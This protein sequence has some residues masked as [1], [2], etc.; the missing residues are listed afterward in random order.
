MMK[1]I[2]WILL[3]TYFPFRIAGQERRLQHR[4]Y[5]DMRKFHYGFTIGLHNQGI[6]LVNNGYIDPSTGKQWFAVNDRYDAGLSVG[7]LGEWRLNTYLAL[8]VIPSMHFGNKHITFREQAS[9]ETTTQNMKSTYISLPI[10]LKISAPRFNNYRPYIIAGLNPMYDLTTR[11]QDYLLAKPLNLFFEVGLGC[12]FYL[13]FFKIIPELKFCFGL[14]NILEKDRKDLV[15]K[16]NAIFT[17]SVNKG[18]ANMIIL[19]LYFE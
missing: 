7:V 3:F 12:D 16:T 6:D 15:D 9:G 18:V 19:S 14:G 17:E 4:P 13:P 5:I 8:R 10:D 1:F 2:L 11:K